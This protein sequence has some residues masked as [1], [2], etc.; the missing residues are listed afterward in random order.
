MKPL[1]GIIGRLRQH[2]NK[3]GGATH[4][5]R[6]SSPSKQTSAQSKKSTNSS[7]A[8]SSEDFGEFSCKA[9]QETYKYYCKKADEAISKGDNKMADYWQGEAADFDRRKGLGR[10][11]K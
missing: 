7:S 4:A 1:R 10:F 6:I 2:I 9:H 11:S 3:V 8:S 5:N